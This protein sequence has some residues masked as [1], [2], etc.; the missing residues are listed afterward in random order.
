MT[1]H[2][3]THRATEGTLSDSKRFG[4][5]IDE[6]RTRLEEDY[7]DADTES[8]LAPI[9]SLARSRRF[10]QF[11]GDGLVVFSSPDGMRRFRT[12][13]GFEPSVTV[14]DSFNFREI[15][16][17][18]TGDV[19]FLLL[20]ISRAKAR[21]FEADRGHITELPLGDIPTSYED[22]EGAYTR[23]PQLQA[24]GG[25][26]RHAFFHGH[27]PGESNV[28]DAYL[29]VAG[30]AVEKRFTNDPRPVVLASVPE[31]FGPLSTHLNTVRLIGD[32]VAGNPDKLSP[33]QLH[34]KAWPL[35]ATEVDRHTT[36]LLDDYAAALGTGLATGDAGAIAADARVGRIGTLLVSKKALTDEAYA[37][38]IDDAVSGVLR[39]SGEIWA[40]EELPDGA[41]AGAL[42]RY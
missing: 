36:A 7:P 30:R 26:G 6:A 18:V 9:E 14:G 29:R 38:D 2:V 21:L 41:A 33:R 32:T 4:H 1:I 17:M 12:D 39:T 27:G 13:E 20:A 8:I 37:A 31:Y 22:V 5:L 23:E 28:L 16:P 34:E 24:Q 19:P 42:R 40:V 3:P 15:L 25:P 35:A 10:W 11:Q